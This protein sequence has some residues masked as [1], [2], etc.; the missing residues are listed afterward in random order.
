[1]RLEHEP[2]ASHF[3]TGQEIA[4]VAPAVACRIRLR[5]VWA[6]VTGAKALRP[7]IPSAELARLIVVIWHVEASRTVSIGVGWIY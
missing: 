2:R 4:R 7:I 6:N 1:M 5:Q 3:R